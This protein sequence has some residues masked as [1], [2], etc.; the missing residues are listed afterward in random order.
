[1]RKEKIQNNI[2][3]IGHVNFGKLITT[4][5]LSYKLGGIANL[6]IE[7]FE[8]KT[9][10]MKK[11]S[12]KY[13]WVLDNFKAERERGITIDIALWKF[14][15]YIVEGSNVLPTKTHYSSSLLFIISSSSSDF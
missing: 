7:R 8:R 9:S 11:C 6:I 3:V 1:M 14:V 2:V 12:L 5:H 15:P 4:N 13:T 10:K